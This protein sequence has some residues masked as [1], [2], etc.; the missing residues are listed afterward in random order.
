M[1]I[2]PSPFFLA[3][4]GTR[5][6]D[7][8]YSNSVQGAMSIIT[9]TEIEDARIAGLEAQLVSLTEIVKNTRS[10][11]STV[12]ITEQLFA[13]DCIKQPPQTPR[14]LQGSRSPRSLTPIVVSPTE[15]LVSD[16]HD[17]EGADNPFDTP[18]EDRTCRGRKKASE[19]TASPPTPL[20]PLLV[21]SN[22]S[23]E[24][25]SPTL[26]KGVQRSKVHR[27]DILEG[28]QSVGIEGDEDFKPQKLIKN[29]TFE[30]ERSK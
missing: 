27:Q 23:M 11:P 16:G 20:T 25:E 5:L 15:S 26:R 2:A 30:M 24:P 4:A 13:K 21:E 8:K 22:D 12:G 29:M 9:I 17:G 6:F 10:S 3:C 18:Y 19:S 1:R 14:Y 28:Y 7:T